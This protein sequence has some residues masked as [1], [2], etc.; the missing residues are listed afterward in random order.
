LEGDMLQIVFDRKKTSL[1]FLKSRRQAIEERL[2]E[3]SG[4]QV[5]VDFKTTEDYNKSHVEMYGDK[6]LF[7]EWQSKVDM[8]I[9]FD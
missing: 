6:D 2:S 7:R 5:A 8:E 1:E 3:V 9:N 4:R